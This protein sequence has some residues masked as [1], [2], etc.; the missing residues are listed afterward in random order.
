MNKSSEDNMALL[1]P[2]RRAK[3]DGAREPGR[4][5]RSKR[6]PDEP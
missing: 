5:G 1:R 2:G 6:S 3:D 4:A